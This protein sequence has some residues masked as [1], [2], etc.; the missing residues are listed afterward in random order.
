MPFT[1]TVDGVQLHY[2]CSGPVEGEP[3]LLLHGLGVDGDGWVLQRRA[4]RH[5]RVLTLDNRGVGR[6][7]SPPG[8][9]DLATMASD[10][11]TVLDAEGVEAAHV[12]GASMGGVLAQLLA[13]HHPGRVRSLVLA[14]TACRHERWRRLLLTDWM[15]AAT[16]GSAPALAELTTPFL[17][18]SRLLRVLTRLA[19][20]RQRDQGREPLGGFVSQAAA[21]LGMDDR[22]AERLGDVRVPTLVAVGEHDLLTTPDDAAEVAAR[23]R[24][25]RFEVLT[26]VAHAVMV[27][28]WWR[29]N[30]LLATFLGEVASPAPAS[31]APPLAVAPAG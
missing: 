15:E 25:A 10:A 18:E 3:V 29:F 16:T 11:V 22:L 21:L 4:L 20:R 30:R 13:I 23:I 5:H 8:P 7:D 24:G 12:V 19:R 6:S 2:R 28:R 9:Y 31:T 27:E 14:A 1:E 26:G 17:F